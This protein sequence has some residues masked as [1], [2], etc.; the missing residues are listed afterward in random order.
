MDA[1]ADILA[2]FGI[3]WVGLQLEKQAY[4]KEENRKLRSLL[5][6]SLFSAHLGQQEL[7]ES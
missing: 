1:I 4:K 6:E 5:E 3:L 2:G 7:R